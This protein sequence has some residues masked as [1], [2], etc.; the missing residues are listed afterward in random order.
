MIYVD[1]VKIGD[2]VT[3]KNKEPGV[4]KA[5][6]DDGLVRVVYHCDNDWENYQNYTSALTLTK[7]LDYGWPQSV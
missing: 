5:F 3:Y 7:D 2:K 1:Y 6:F 4:I